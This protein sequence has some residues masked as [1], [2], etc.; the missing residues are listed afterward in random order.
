M[1][2]D[3]KIVLTAIALLDDTVIICASAVVSTKSGKLEGVTQGAVE[4]FKGVPFAAPPVGE[5]RWRAPQPVNHGRECDRPTPIRQTV[6]RFRFRVML[7]LWAPP[8]P[9]IACT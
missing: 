6:C 1:D 7:L 8:L 9:R 4:S 3:K 2:T 5:L